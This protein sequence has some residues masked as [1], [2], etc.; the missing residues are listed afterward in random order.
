NYRVERAILDA[1]GFM[2]LLE[3]EGLDPLEALNRVYILTAFSPEQQMALAE[4]AERLIDESVSLVIVDGAARLLRDEKRLSPK[5]QL[6]QRAI[7]RLKTLCAERGI[8]LVASTGESK[9]RGGL[10]EPEGGT[11]LKHLASV[12]LYLKKRR[13]EAPYVKALLLKHPSKGPVAFEYAYGKVVELGRSTP[14]IRASFEETVSRLRKRFKDALI[15]E[16]RREALES[17]I[18][19]WSSELGALNYAEG[20]TLLDLMLLTAAI[21]NRRLLLELL[22]RVEALEERLNA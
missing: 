11:Y 22:N 5:R 14:S 1:E 9:K 3:A 4:K 6:V 15:D 7:E 10:P 19:A 2:H 13:P 21:D 18:E 16:E 12:I 8:P 17:L 20:F